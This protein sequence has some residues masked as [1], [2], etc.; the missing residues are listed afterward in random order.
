M[1][2]LLYYLIVLSLSSHFKHAIVYVPAKLEFVNEFDN[3]HRIVSN[4]IQFVYVNKFLYRSYSINILLSFEF[5]LFI[6]LLLLSRFYNMIFQIKTAQF[7]YTLMMTN[8][9]TLLLL[10]SSLYHFL[11]NYLLIFCCIFTNFRTSIKIVW[12]FRLHLHF[13]L[14]IYFRS[15]FMATINMIRLLPFWLSGCLR[16][17]VNYA[18]VFFAIE[19]WKSLLPFV[20]FNCNWSSPLFRP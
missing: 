19:G 2:F 18:T 9:L 8:I 11:C 12:N 17:I 16:Y 15:L 5:C 4:F 20:W 13:R 10:L 1:H 3:K 14:I 7:D 6:L